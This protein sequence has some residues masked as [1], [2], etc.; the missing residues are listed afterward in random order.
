MDHWFIWTNETPMNEVGLREHSK[1]QGRRVRGWAGHAHED[2]DLRRL[3]LVFVRVVREIKGSVE[4]AE[5]FRAVVV[6]DLLEP[7][8]VGVKHHRVVLHPREPAS[9]I[10][11]QRSQVTRMCTCP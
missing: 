7:R 3:Q 1:M 10:G 5:L 2:L 9:H 11:T 6:A 4:G 8:C